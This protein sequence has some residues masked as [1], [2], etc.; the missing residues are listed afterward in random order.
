MNATAPINVPRLIRLATLSF[1]L[2]AGTL[3][4]FTFA[5]VAGGLQQ[6]IDDAQA[7]LRS[8]EVAFSEAPHVRDER[9]ALGRR[10]A[11]L[12]A[13]N[14]EAVFLREL[15]ADVH[16]SGVTLLSTSV[17]QDASGSKA[18][19]TPNA[20]LAPTRMQIE[21]RG[22]YR[23]VLSAVA[24]LS[25]GSEIVNVAAPSL[26]RDGDAVIASIPVTIY[27]PQSPAENVPSANAGLR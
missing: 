17:T 7:T 26:R 23:R 21:L 1:A 13:Q 22:S 2:L 20:L 3:V 25:L 19:S 14:P 10:Y 8:D 6:R 9:D 27:E 5:P 11:A 18:G 24:E 15:S 12:F 16:A 4:Y